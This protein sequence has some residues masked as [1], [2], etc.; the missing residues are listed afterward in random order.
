M[1]TVDVNIIM[2]RISVIMTMYNAERFLREAIE[3]I[4]S[5]T[6]RNF[7]FIIF[8][9]GSTDNSVAI[10]ESY[11]DPRIRLFRSPHIGRAATLNKAV[12]AAKTGLLAFMDA[13]DIA[14]PHRMQMQYD[15]MVND[16]T[17]DTVSSSYQL[18]D[19]RGN[20]IREKHLPVSHEAIVELMPMQC[21]VCFGAA[22]IRTSI[23]LQAGMFDEKLTTAIDYD[24]W[25]RI[26]D[27]AKFY[28]IS[29][30]LV[31]VR[32]SNTSIS[33]R[34]RNVQFRHTYEMGMHYL[35]EKYR[36]AQGDESK[37]KISLQLGKLEYYY[38][39]MVN[40]RKYF[41]KILWNKPYMF[42]AWRFYIASFLGSR[43]FMLL[44]STGLADR[45]GNIFK[46]SSRKYDYFMP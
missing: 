26:L 16:E 41:V 39:T 18:I 33:S 25:L 34:F 5:Q 44:R 9:D 6:Y 36:N 19:E 30:S 15:T 28:N 23:L 4:L 24:L 2:P 8:D 14:L 37:A 40:A 43:I 10:A 1:S 20:P 45:I 29:N 46:K 27:R 12:E 17:I 7:E 3:S 21:S 42:V 38:G 22:L 13:D 32:I 35:E 11:N 31:K